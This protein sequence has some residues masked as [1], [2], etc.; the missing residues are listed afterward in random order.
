M[1]GVAFSESFNIS[2]GFGVHVELGQ[3]RR[4]GCITVPMV[5]NN[6]IIDIM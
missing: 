4:R 3:G 1:V 5:K 6:E 2:K